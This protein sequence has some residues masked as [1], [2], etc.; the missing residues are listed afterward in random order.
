MPSFYRTLVVAGAALSSGI[1][2]GDS[3]DLGPL[4]QA[5]AS[6]GGGGDSTVG[7]FGA[8]SGSGGVGLSGTDGG[9]GISPGGASMGGAP[10]GGAPMGGAPMGGFA[11]AI[12]DAALAQ[13]SCGP[14]ERCWTDPVYRYVETC[15][16][17]L[18]RPRSAA[19]CPADTRFECSPGLLKGRRVLVECT[20]SNS[21]PTS[22]V[23]CYEARDP[24][25]CEG[26][27]RV[28]GC[29]NPGVLR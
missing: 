1:G 8:N 9:G 11:G 12:G 26:E 28:C 25:G 17:D 10:M 23:R 24:L 5:D 6:T 22:C 15:V 19:D 7:G 4:A 16:V 20:C 13:L 18:S 3:A 21:E 29:A 2:C 14:H 27:V